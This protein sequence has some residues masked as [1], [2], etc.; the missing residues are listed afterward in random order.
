MSKTPLGAKIAAHRKKL[1]LS[2]SQL[3]DKLG[4]KKCRLGAWEEGRANPNP[5]FLVKL[6]EEF[7][8]TVDNLLKPEDEKVQDLQADKAAD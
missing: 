6:A 8:T 3:A 1:K 4:I 2:Q 7:K 5:D